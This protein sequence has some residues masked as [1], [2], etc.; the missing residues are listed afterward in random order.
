MINWYIID[1]STSGDD[2]GRRQIYL[3]KLIVVLYYNKIATTYKFKQVNLTQY[4]Q[5]IIRF[6]CSKRY[7]N[8]SVCHM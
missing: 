8:N 1:T 2:R 4:T 6:I 7:C 5:Y 3:Y